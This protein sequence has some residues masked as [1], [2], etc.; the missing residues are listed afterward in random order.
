M[1]VV[2]GGPGKAFFAWVRK[3]KRRGRERMQKLG[4]VGGRT[5]LLEFMLLFGFGKGARPQKI[6][7]F[8][9]TKG[10]LRKFFP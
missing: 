3:N 10:R 2:V 8:Y 5:D 9:Q 7:D 4:M 6:G 1:A